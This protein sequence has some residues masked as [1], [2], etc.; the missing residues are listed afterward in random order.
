MHQRTLHRSPTTADRDRRR[1]PWTLLVESC[2]PGVDISGFDAFRAAGFDVTVCEG[3]AA[4]ARECPVVRGEGC[5]LLD[6]AD[7]VLFDLDSDPPLRSAVVAAIQARRPD[8]PM[9]V[10]SAAPPTGAARR[11]PTIRTTTSVNGQIS[12][13]RKAVLRPAGPRA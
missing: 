2:E 6:G 11:C 12:A 1:P 8:L 13:L 4:D 3:P 9:V 10:R 5:P 7:V